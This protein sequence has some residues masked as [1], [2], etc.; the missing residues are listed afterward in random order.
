MREAL[1]VI[2]TQQ[3]ASS[4]HKLVIITLPPHTSNF[5]LPSQEAAAMT[6]RP[7]T[8]RRAVQASA[9]GAGA[10]RMGPQSGSGKVVPQQQGPFTAT[11]IFQREVELFERAYVLLHAIEAIGCQRI[12]LAKTRKVAMFGRPPSSD[13]VPTCGAMAQAVCHTIQ[14]RRARC[15]GAVHIEGC[16]P[17]A[18]KRHAVPAFGRV[19]TRRRGA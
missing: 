8:R 14:S 10:S 16:A 4:S 17:R 13:G 2:Q 3:H 18:A 12:A 15:L 1:R 11:G 9:G 19:S 7:A 5:E 6:V